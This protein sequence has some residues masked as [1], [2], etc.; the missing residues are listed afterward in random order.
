MGLDGFIDSRHE[1]ERPLDARDHAC[2]MRKFIRRKRSPAAI[3]QPFPQYLMRA[4]LELPGGRRDRFKLQSRPE[5]DAVAEKFRIARRDR[6][7]L[8]ADELHRRHRQRRIA[9]QVQ[10]DECFTERC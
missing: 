2:V 4:D 9:Q 7:V 10:C 6:A 1:R 3:L 5:C 8:I